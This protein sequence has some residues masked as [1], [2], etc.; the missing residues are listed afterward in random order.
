[1]VVLGSYSGYASSADR[2]IQMPVVGD[3]QA[4]VEAGL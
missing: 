4:A 2:R 3:R 1:V